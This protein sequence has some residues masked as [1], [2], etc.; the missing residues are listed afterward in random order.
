MFQCQ[1]CK[2]PFS[3]TL[4]TVFFGLKISSETICRALACLAEGMRIRV[5]AR[6]F[7]VKKDTVLRLLRRA[8]EHSAMVSAYLMRNLQVEQA[9]LDELWTFVFKKERKGKRTKIRGVLKAPVKTGME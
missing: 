8:G 9:Q 3:E 5:T 1:W 4:G 7:W 2:N 6:V